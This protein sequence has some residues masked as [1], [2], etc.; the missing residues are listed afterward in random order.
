[1]EDD[2]AH[3]DQVFVVDTPVTRKITC[4]ASEQITLIEKA[5]R[6]SALM[7]LSKDASIGN[8]LEKVNTL[9]R[10]LIENT[11]IK[12]WL[13]YLEDE[14]EPLNIVGQLSVWFRK[15]S[16]LRALVQIGAAQVPDP[17][18][19]TVQVHG[20]GTTS[21]EYQCYGDVVAGP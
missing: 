15:L 6:G 3:L 9:T 8:L 1:M 21:F 11:G 5:I 13:T 17:V 19:V 16:V 4:W 20:I 18:T 7:K 14:A 10:T 12:A 2:R